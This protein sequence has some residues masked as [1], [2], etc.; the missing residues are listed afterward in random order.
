MAEETTIREFGQDLANLEGRYE[1]EMRNVKERLDKQDGKLDDILGA[2]HNLDLHR[3]ET[4]GRD[5]VLIWGGSGVIAM[6]SAWASKHL[7]LG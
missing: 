7:G 2:I 6:A 4:T 1:V 5:R 3:A